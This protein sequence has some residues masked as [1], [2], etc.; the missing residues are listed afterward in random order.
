M[1]FLIRENALLKVLAFP[2]DR[3]F[4]LA[5]RS[6]VPVKTVVRDVR[7]CT[8]KPFCEGWVCPITNGGPFGKPV[9]G[10]S[11]FRPKLVRIVRGSFIE[12]LKFLH[13]LDCG[14][15]AEF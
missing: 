15:F 11:L 13:G 7:L 2:D 8:D 12:R 4:V 1:Q 5:P 9:D 6:Q 10:A 14:T 3:R